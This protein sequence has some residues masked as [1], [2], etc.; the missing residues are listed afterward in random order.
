MRSPSN[1]PNLSSGNLKA[2]EVGRVQEPEET[3]YTRRTSHSASMEQDTY[4]RSD[5]SR[6]HRAYRDLQK[7]LRIIAISLVFFFFYGSFDCENNLCLLSGL[8]S[9]CYVAMSKFDMIAFAPSYLFVMFVLWLLSLRSLLFSKERF[10]RGLIKRG[11]DG[12]KYLE[13]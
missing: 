9:S 1:S 11:G 6:K 5:G 13:D 8:Y 4:E 10:K 2:E 3:V 7:V 12:R